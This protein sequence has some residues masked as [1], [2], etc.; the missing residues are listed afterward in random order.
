MELEQKV[1]LHNFVYP[2]QAVIFKN[3]DLRK[4]TWL[5]QMNLKK[6]YV[7][8]EKAGCCKNPFSH[9]RF[10]FN[11]E[12]ILFINKEVERKGEMVKST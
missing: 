5:Y 3:D 8:K 7:V 6:K 9:G 4:C 2:E 1:G 10:H 12:N 11:L